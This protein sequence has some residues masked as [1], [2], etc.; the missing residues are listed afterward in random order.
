MHACLAALSDIGVV[1]QD[2]VIDETA[3]I[4]EL[5]H[6]LKYPT[7]SLIK[8]LN[9]QPALPIVPTAPKE[10]LVPTG[11]VIPCYGIWEPVRLGHPPAKGMTPKGVPYELGPSRDVDGRTLDGCLNYLHGDFAAPTIAF[12]EDL[13]RHDGR[14]T[15]WRLVWR[16]DRYGDK[17]VPEEESDYVFVRPVEGEVLFKYG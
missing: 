4:S 15:T 9:A 11:D 13:P 2:R 1:L 3:A 14:P 8:H 7:S 5:S 17:G 6:Y 12:Q 16:D 10:V